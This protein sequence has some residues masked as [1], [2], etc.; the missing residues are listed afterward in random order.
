MD[1]VGLRIDDENRAREV[2]RQGTAI[3]VRIERQ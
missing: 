1:C 2:R 3:V